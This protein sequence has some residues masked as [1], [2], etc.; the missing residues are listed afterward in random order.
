HDVFV[1]DFMN[2]ADTITDAFSE[3]YRATLLSE[4]T[5]PN[6]LHDLQGQ[7]D[8]R[9]SS[10]CFPARAA[11][12]PPPISPICSTS[13]AGSTTKSP[14]SASASPPPCRRTPSSQS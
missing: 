8:A 1:L 4:E 14:T 13:P 11:A 5:D 9:R 7:L 12:K 2:D 10:A 6:K 3:Y